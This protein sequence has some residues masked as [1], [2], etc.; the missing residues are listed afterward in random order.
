LFRSQNELIIAELISIEVHA[1]IPWTRIEFEIDSTN[2][3]KLH[4]SGITCFF[5]SSMTIESRLASQESLLDVGEYG[6][7]NAAVLNCAY[8]KAFEVKYK[9][10]PIHLIGI[11]FKQ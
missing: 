7:W 11:C 1:V 5:D 3:L 10:N 4:L 2:P 9:S 6:L 8:T